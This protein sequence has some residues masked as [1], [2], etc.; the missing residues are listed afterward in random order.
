[1]SCECST[2]LSSRYLHGY[3]VVCTAVERA[4]LQS[5][6]GGA[7]PRGCYSLDVMKDLKVLRM[8]LVF[9]TYGL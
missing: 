1:M 3:Y 6:G 2:P 4:G 7:Y 8:L 5:F 9:P